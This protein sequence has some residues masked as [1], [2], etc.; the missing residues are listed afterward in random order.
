M[1]AA[2]EAA[3]M[4]VTDLSINVYNDIEKPDAT[5]RAKT[6]EE[7]IEWLMLTD[8]GGVQITGTWKAG[9]RR[10]ELELVYV[11]LLSPSATQAFI[12]RFLNESIKLR[13]AKELMHLKNPHVELLD[14]VR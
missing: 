4:A 14:S 13:I 5:R 2:P 3:S 7:A 6:L 12:V 10:G 1:A 11:K 8:N 9:G